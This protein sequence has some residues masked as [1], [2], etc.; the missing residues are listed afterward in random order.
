MSMVIDLDDE[1]REIL[2]IV[3]DSIAR[4]QPVEQALR[5]NGLDPTIAAQVIGDAVGDED[6][7]PECPRGTVVAVGRPEYDTGHQPYACDAG[8]G[9]GG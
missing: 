6:D 3:A 4:S 5:A 1:A 8:C 7:C 2:R 9:Y